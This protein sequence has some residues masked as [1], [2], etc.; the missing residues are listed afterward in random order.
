AKLRLGR[1][2]D[3]GATSGEGVANL[4]CAAQGAVGLAGLVVG[5]AGAGFVDPL[6]AVVISAVAARE[7]LELWRGNECDCHSMPH[8]DTAPRAAD[9]CCDD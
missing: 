1:T 9:R 4:I 2:L 8:L 3:S 6:A 5:G 7:G